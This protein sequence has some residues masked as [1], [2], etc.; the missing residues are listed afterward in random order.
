M[1]VSDL[2]GVR[3]LTLLMTEDESSRCA[4]SKR[5]QQHRPKGE[6]VR[7]ASR[8]Y[9]SFVLIPPRLADRNYDGFH[10]FRA[11]DP[12]SGE[13]RFHG[14]SS[15][16]GTATCPHHGYAPQMGDSAA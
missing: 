13:S 16:T 5:D 8:L 3:G 15:R 12:V 4:D 1:S 10:T 6:P 14:E 11:P 9:I 2:L 7:C